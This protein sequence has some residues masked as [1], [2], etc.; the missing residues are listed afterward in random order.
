MFLNNEIYQLLKMDRLESSNKRIWKNRDGKKRCAFVHTY[1]YATDSGG[2]K[3]VVKLPENAWD[4]TVDRIQGTQKHQGNR[5]TKKARLRGSK[6]LKQLPQWQ[7]VLDGVPFAF[8]YLSDMQ[9]DILTRTAL[10]KKKSLI[11][12]DISCPGRKYPAVRI[13]YLIQDAYQ[14]I[15]FHEMGERNMAN[16]SI[17]M[18]PSAK[19]MLDMVV[20]DTG[21]DRT[22][23][24]NQAIFD[25]LDENIT[26]H[27]AVQF[28]TLS[29]IMKILAKNKA[30]GITEYG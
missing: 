8:P 26:G 15:R 23:H 19:K 17:N 2:K 29:R 10:G 24:I 21:F 13:R 3:H 22:Y 11:A 25:Y 7:T 16:V 5:K 4:E 14:K 18:E 1:I 30:K 6:D 28:K 12:R 9:N 27:F 20:E